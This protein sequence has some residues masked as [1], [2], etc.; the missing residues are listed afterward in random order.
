M[1]IDLKPIGGQTMTVAKLKTKQPSA[2]ALIVGER[3]LMKALVKEALDEVLDAEMTE[4]LGAG[5]ASAR[6]SARAT[7]LATTAAG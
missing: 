7:V 4:V 5:R 2:K 6:R 1:T 3:D